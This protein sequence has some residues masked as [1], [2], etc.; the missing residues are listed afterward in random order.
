LI[1]DKGDQDRSRSTRDLETRSDLLEF[2]SCSTDR[3]DDDKITDASE[4]EQINVWSRMSVCVHENIRAR[5][6]VCVFVCVC[7]CTWNKRND[8]EKGGEVEI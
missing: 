5:A 2:L 3:C 4:N 8:G 6:C 1:E 7:A